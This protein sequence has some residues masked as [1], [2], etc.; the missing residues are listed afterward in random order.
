VL[1]RH[2][3]GGAST[4]ALLGLFAELGPWLATREGPPPNVAAVSAAIADDRRAERPHILDRTARG[5][6]DAKEGE[7]LLEAMRWIDRLGYHA[8]RAQHHLSEATPAS[9][10]DRGDESY[11]IA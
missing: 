6:L 2:K 9:P 3:T 4:H 10:S 11:D 7:E 5:E 8:S 1:D